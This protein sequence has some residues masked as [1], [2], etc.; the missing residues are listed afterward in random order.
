MMADYPIPIITGF[1]GFSSAGR[2]SFHQAYQRIIF[3]S[4]DN[5]AQQQVILGLA[6]LMKLVVFRNGCYEDF[7]T[8][9][10]LSVENISFEYGSLILSS[11]L[12]RRIELFDD[13]RVL[14]HKRIKIANNKDHPLTF[15]L[16]K[17]QLPE[18][19]P[20]DW[21]LTEASNNEVIISIQNAESTDVLIEDFKSIPVK[22][23]GQLPTGFHPGEHYKSRFHP[24]GLQMTITA[25]SDAINSM[26]ID[27]QDIQSA[28]NPDELN[29]YSG[30]ALGQLDEFSFAGLLQARLKG[31][32]V[33]SKQFAMGL[34]SMP[35]DFVNAYVLGNLG[36]SMTSSGACASFLYNLKQACHDIQAG[37]C[38]VA[39]VGN[40]EAPITAEIIEGFSSMGALATEENLR[41]L[42]GLDQV[43]YRNSSRPFANNCGFTLAESSQF[44]VLMCDELV[45][46][47]GANIHGSVPEVFINADGFKKSISAPGA[48]NYIT[49]AK[50][51]A[52][53]EQMLGADAV[54][55][56][57][58][59][60]SHGSS[61]P[62]NRVTESD[63]LDKV[64]KAFDIREWP[65]TAVKSY[66]GHPLGPAGGDQLINSLG[67]F[68]YG[69][70]PA[71]NN[72]DEI[73]EDVSSDN[74]NFLTQHY[75]HKNKDLAVGF[76]NSKGFGGNNATAV[77]VSPKETLKMLD[78]RYSHEQMLDYK[79]ANTW[80][81]NKAFEYHQQA[82]QGNLN[83]I[84]RFG[85]DQIEGGDIRVSTES[86]SFNWPECEVDLTNLCPYS[87][88]L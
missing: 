54:K 56:H 40:S 26:G 66:L 79:S 38:K 13:T 39:I 52:Y 76:L 49:M 74:L 20:K 21:I 2:S 85:E 62:A 71:I 36:G 77:L 69:I 63:I 4:L 68:E 6:T 5:D 28:I 14:Q 42:D 19:I 70:I 87:I 44:I 86:V 30:S 60:Q 48:G 3:D 15:K 88:K 29:V 47:L 27:W 53:A 55:K 78:L 1:G 9:K 82:Q 17:S 37:K 80:V 33:S 67:C 41:K 46:D 23:A 59:V 10:A 73:A 8:E 18:N 64:A 25:V 58:F 50:A 84:Y 45:L 81:K 16:S 34:N 72:L 32:R 75:A 12:I 83:T 22:S 24:R 57:S 7:L 65:V 51:V 43:D 11:T 35:T 61:T 31:N